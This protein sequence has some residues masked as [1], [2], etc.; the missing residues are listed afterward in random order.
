METL[1]AAREFCSYFTY[2]YSLLMIPLDI[3][4]PPCIPTSMQE[5]T[6]RSVSALNLACGPSMHLLT[7]EG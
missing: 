7:R 5:D 2:F 4:F 3:Y 1:G 6:L